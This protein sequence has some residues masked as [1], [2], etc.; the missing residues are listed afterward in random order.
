MR[1]AA[2]GEHQGLCHLRGDSRAAHLCNTVQEQVDAGGDPGAAVDGGIADKHAV[3]DDLTRRGR[4]L[5]FIQMLV[6]GGR[7]LAGEQAGMRG[8]YGPGTHRD[9]LGAAGFQLQGL[10]PMLGRSHGRRIHADGL[11]RLPQKDHPGGVFQFCGQ[12][13]KAGDHGPD[14]AGRLA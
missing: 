11:A 2:H 14:R 13:C 10:Q 1:S 6:V 4:R 3:A 12:G 9:Q 8:E 5:Q 7:M